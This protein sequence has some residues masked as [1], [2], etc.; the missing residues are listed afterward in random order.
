ML[1]QVAKTVNGADAY[2]HVVSYLITL[3]VVARERVGLLLYVLLRHDMILL[4]G[5]A[6][7]LKEVAKDALEV[8]DDH[9]VLQLVGTTTEIVPKCSLEVLIS[10][11]VQLHFDI[12]LLNLCRLRNNWLLGLRLANLLLLL[13]LSLTLFA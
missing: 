10:L 2:P 12:F 8:Y 4:R 3:I 13:E 9:W 7:V 1:G 11:R 5:D 6:S